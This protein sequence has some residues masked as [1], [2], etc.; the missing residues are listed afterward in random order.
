MTE[1]NMAEEKQMPLTEHLEELRSRL[2]VCVVT[3]LVGF[4]VSYGFKEQLFA[5]VARPLNIAMGE[6]GKLIFTSLTEPFIAYL[7]ISFFGGIIIALPV[8]LYE[9]WAFVAPG[10]YSKEKKVIFPLVFL[11]CLFFAGG[12]SFGY[13]I[14]FPMGFKVLLAF[15]GDVADALPSM[16]EYLGLAT[17]LLIAFGVVFE[18]P[19]F[20]VTFSRMGM[21]TPQMLRKGR[22]YALVIFVICGAILT[23]PD[24]FSQLMMA[25]PLVILYEISI[26]GAVIFGKKPEPETD[27]DDIDDID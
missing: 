16:K 4:F 23:P 21:V 9:I 3:V 8:I 13:F 18:L 6:G 15:G 2:I 22:K 19:L 1:E 17:K 26:I 11:G 25:A 10:L 14:V 5:L 27:V 12:A 20:I 24:P 7:K